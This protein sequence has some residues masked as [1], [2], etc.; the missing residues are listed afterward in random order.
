MTE[1]FKNRLVTIIGKRIDLILL[2][3]EDDLSNYLKW[4]NDKQ[5][6]KY[7]ESGRSETTLE[8][9]KD[10]I[11]QNNSSTSVLLGIFEKRSKKHIGNIKLHLIDYQNKSGEIGIMIGET[12]AQGQG[13]AFEAIR[14][15]IDYAFFNLELNRVT[16]GMVVD[17]VGSKK[18]FEKAGFILEGTLR[19]SFFSNGFFYD[20]HRLAVL[21]SDYIKK[22]KKEVD[23]G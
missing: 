5:V 13:Y 2:S 3:P 12:S 7:L 8:S 6:T 14:L 17:N 21:K 22:I 1:K 4:M 11:K 23:K 20:C 19:E 16:T 18:A 10:Y 9:L 15:V